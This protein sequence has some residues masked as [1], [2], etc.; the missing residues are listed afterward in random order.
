MRTHKDLDIWKLGLDLVEQ[1]YS[2]TKL[3][4]DDEKFGLSSQLRRA[5]V[6]VPSNIAEGAA[7]NSNKEYIQFL[8]HITGLSVRSRDSI[9]SYREIVHRFECTACIELYR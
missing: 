6:S 2:T 1:I 3:L 9:N 4:P 5:G 8:L 7:R